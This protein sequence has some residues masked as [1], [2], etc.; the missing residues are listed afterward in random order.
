[1]EIDGNQLKENVVKLTKRKGYSMKFIAQQVEMSENGLNGA[2]LKR[3]IKFSVLEKIAELL[4]TSVKTV[5]YFHQGG[6]KF[7]PYKDKYLSTLEENQRLN[8][9]VREL[10]EK[11]G[12][13]ENRAGVKSANGN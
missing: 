13:N 8:R 5:L 12:K 11:Y 3:T 7:D 4:E 6:D 1:M 9:E 10:Q 2:L